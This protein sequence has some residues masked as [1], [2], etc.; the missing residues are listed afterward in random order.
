MCYVAFHPKEWRKLLLYVIHT[1][2]FLTSNKRMYICALSVNDYV[3]KF[4]LSLCYLAFLK[5]ISSFKFWSCFL[6]QVTIT[7]YSTQAFFVQ[8]VET[9]LTLLERKD[10]TIWLSLHHIQT[11]IVKASYHRWTIQYDIESLILFSTKLIV[12]V[13]ICLFS[14]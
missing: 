5:H 1:L 11:R 14:H 7:T 12:F 9:R 2:S 10:D 4:Q 6:R 13:L 8:V 3:E